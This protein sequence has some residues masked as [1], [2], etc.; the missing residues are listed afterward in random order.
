MNLLTLAFLGVCVMQAPK[1]DDAARD[2]MTF[3]YKNP[4][5]EKFVESVRELA[6]DGSLSNDDAQPP[7]V[8]FL[9]QVMA[10]NP[11]KIPGWLKQLSD[12]DRKQTSVILAAAWYSDTEEALAYFESQKLEAYLKQKGPKILEMELD[13]T[14]LD[15]LWGHFMATGDEKPIRRIVSA[16][17]LSKYAG[18]AERFKTSEK[19]E[20]DKK[21]AFLDA[22]FQAAKW[23][24][25]SN[26][27]QHPKVLQHCEAML[28][29]RQLSDD[30]RL[31]LGVVLA[32][33]KPDKYGVKLIEKDGK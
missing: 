3:Y 2:W 4:T 7:I 29:D 33:V 10:S 19:T 6:K 22:T 27:R 18:A 24:L 25:E 15:M 12:L 16:F 28:V 20:Q 30:Q 5:P 8:A 9:S 13:P 14:I 21:E 17:S 32:K 23:S 11:K 31:W 1:A 26:C